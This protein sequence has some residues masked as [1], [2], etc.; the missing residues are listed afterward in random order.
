[1]ATHADSSIAATAAA[2]HGHISWGQL[3]AAG[4]SIRQAK[5]RVE[6]GRLLRVYPGVYRVAAV[7]PSPHGAHMAAVLATGGVASHRSSAWLLG[8]WDRPPRQ[9]EL[10][11]PR[12]LGWR[13]DLVTHRLVDLARHDVTYVDGI[14]CTDSARL[15]VDLGAVCRPKTVEKLFHKML[16][17]KHTDFDTIVSR[18]FQ[19]SRRGRAG[20][21]VLRAILDAYDPSM[22]PAESDLGVVLLQVLRDH[23]LPA[24]VRQHR[25]VVDGHRYRL[26]VCYPELKMAMEGDGFGVHSERDAFE[27][28]RVRQNRLVL[29]GWFVLRYTWRMLLHNPWQAAKDTFDARAMRTASA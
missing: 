11:L 8:H 4:L 18:Y 21:G 6:T 9:V 24:P 27:E 13:S 12:P 15:L 25:V 14:P 10:T 2:Q 1:M 17:G 29:N 5:Y 22:A 3:L 28:D 19:V 20:A 7:P 16:H 23:G 26:D